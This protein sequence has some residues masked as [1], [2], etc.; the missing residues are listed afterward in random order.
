LALVARES[1]NTSVEN[2]RRATNHG[3]LFLHKSCIMCIEN[4]R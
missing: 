3:Y 4:T 2:Q 1:R